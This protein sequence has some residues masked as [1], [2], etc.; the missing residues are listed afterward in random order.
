[1]QCEIDAF[2]SMHDSLAEIRANII[3]RSTTAFNALLSLGIL[4][5]IAL[6]SFLS[7][8]SRFTRITQ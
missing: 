2:V 7:S 5:R 3:I 8:S 1:M 6:I 4:A